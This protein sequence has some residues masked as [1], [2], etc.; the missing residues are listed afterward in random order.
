MCVAC[1]CVLMGSDIT[2]LVQCFGKV[3]AKRFGIVG[4]MVDMVQR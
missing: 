2:E 3:N 4:N 1:V